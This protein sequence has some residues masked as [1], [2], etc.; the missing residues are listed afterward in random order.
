M[1]ARLI[2]FTGLPGAGKSAIAEALAVELNAPVYS[3]DWLEAPILQTE[4]VPRERLGSL[5]YELLTALARR[6]LM[7]GQTAIL[8]SVASTTSIR[9]AWRVLAEEY[10]ADRFVIE[11]VCSD[12]R[13]HR[14][15]MLGR[16]RNIPG[17]LELEWADVER[18]RGRFE[19]W[20]EVRLILDS[21]EPLQ[22]N[23]K[24]AVRYVENSSA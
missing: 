11:C 13:I 23:V 21:I 4:L 8:D 3:K 10:E 2:V 5:G 20:S 19:P 7:F 1:G 15:R 9:S 12:E 17:W 18:V 14:S 24:K 6:Q 16:T 22:C